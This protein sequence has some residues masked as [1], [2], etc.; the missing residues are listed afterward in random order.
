MPRLSNAEPVFPADAGT[1]TRIFMERTSYRP[2]PAATAKKSDP[3][4][5][6]RVDPHGLAQLADHAGLFIL[7]RIR[8][9]VLLL[10]GFEREP[11]AQLREDPAERLRHVRLQRLGA[12]E[13]PG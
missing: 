5:A 4:T 10:V 3:Q 11:L 12:G 7:A 13:R 1:L 6:L 9:L 2:D 8:L